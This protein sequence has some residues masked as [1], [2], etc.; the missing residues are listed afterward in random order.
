MKSADP[1]RVGRA[2]AAS[3]VSFVALLGVGISAGSAGA[4]GSGAT[5]TDYAT[6]PSELPAG[7]PDGAGALVELSFGNGRG[8][9]SASLGG[10]ALHHGDTVTMS[11]SGVQAA[12]A[13]GGSAPAGGV[14]LAAYRTASLEFDQMVDEELVATVAC[15]TDT[16]CGS[17]P[18]YH[19]SISVPAAQ[20]ACF[21]QLDA[22]LGLALGVV[23]PSGSYYSASLRGSGPNMLISAANFGGDC[24]PTPPTPTPP[25]PTAPTPTSPPPA[26]PTTNPPTVPP[27]VPEAPNPKVAPPGNP[28]ESVTPL[29][30]TK[31]QQLPA[32]GATDTGPTALA[33]LLAL[34]AGGGSLFI[35]RRLTAV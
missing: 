20:D 19:L 16:A 3:F 33:G 10:L 24:T 26:P 18:R 23:G 28:G 1:H 27:T 11:W 7:C 6:Y 14:S 34:I 2:A 32:T 17:G 5:V 8:D 30:V 22:A 25:P 35:S 4:A 31:A 13:G 21:V 12:C 9:E 29:V 15:G